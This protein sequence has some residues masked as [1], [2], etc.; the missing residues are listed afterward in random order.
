VC[1]CVWQ[2]PQLPPACNPYSQSQG[3]Q[4]V[5]SAEG[6]YNESNGKHRRRNRVCA[7]RQP[8]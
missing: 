7:L 3:R 5:A 8:H 6:K 4:R 2:C 1:V